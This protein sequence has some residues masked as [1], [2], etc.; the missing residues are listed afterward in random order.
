MNTEESKNRRVALL[1]G[2]AVL[3]MAIYSISVIV[4]K[5]RPSAAAA[6]SSSYGQR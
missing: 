6:P 2:L 4:A 5:G 3:V 1:L